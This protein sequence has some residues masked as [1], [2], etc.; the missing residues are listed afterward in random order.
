MGKVIAV[1]NQKGGVGKTTTCVN[2]AAALGLLEK[3]VLVIDTDPQANAT[4]SFGF[5]S[6]KLDNPAFEFMS[7]FSIIKNNLLQTTSPNVDLV[8]AFCDIDIFKE[9]NSNSSR[10]KK[11]LEQ[12]TK[13]YDYIFIDCVPFFKAKNLE[14]LSCA[15]SI[16]VP[17]QCDYYALEGVHKFLKT[18]L[19]I[20]K[21]LNKTLE[22]EGFLLTM[23][24]KRLNLSKKVF[25][26]MHEHFK[27]LVFKQIINRNTTI[28]QA[29]SFGK[30]IFEHDVNAIGSQDYLALANEI[31][32]NNTTTK[33][34]NKIPEFSNQQENKFNK[35]ILSVTSNP[36]NIDTLKTNT[37]FN[38]LAKTK[39]TVSKEYIFPNDFNSLLGLDKVKIKEK[40]GLKNNN[41]HS[42]TWVYKYVKTTS[43]FKKKY[44]HLHFKNNCVQSYTTKRTK[45]IKNLI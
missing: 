9:T 4:Q 33:I 26:F 32:R 22:I 5:T 7:L 25:L 28:A 10:F 41:V 43:L 37:L 31:I 21:N 36:I 39:N 42:N 38:K 11:A 13:T 12:I 2:L 6:K 16:I 15:N 19:Y 34:A 20:Q 24:D 3:K 17:V 45:K 35:K 1:C 44:L 27:Q 30:T 29:P 14:I 23:F 8:P 18:I 40:L